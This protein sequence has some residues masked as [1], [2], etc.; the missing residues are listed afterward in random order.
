MTSQ[1][2]ADRKGSQR[3]PVVI[4]GESLGPQKSR[5]PF[6]GGR[7]RLLDRALK[8]AGRTKDEVFTTNVVDWHGPTTI[9]SRG[10]RQCGW[11]CHHGPV[12]TAEHPRRR[13]VVGGVL[14]GVR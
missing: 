11:A 4:V 12:K 5:I 9:G 8:E 3:S 1:S 14:G 2:A 13:E 7:G 6:D 10:H